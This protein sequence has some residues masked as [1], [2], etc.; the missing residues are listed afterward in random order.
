MV[1]K[2][3]T[4]VVTKLFGHQGEIKRGETEVTKEVIFVKTVLAKYNQTL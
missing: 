4:D 2:E 1:S 3:R